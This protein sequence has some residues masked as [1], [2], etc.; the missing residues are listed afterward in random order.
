MKGRERRKGNE[1]KKEEKLIKKYGR[2]NKKWKDTRG[3]SEGK[4]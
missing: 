4:N 2:K 1:R 3:M